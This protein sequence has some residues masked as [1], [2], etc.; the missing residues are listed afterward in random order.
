LRPGQVFRVTL[1]W[2]DAATNETG[3]RVYRDGVV[4]ATLPAKHPSYTDSPPMGGPYTYAVE[5]ISAGTPRRRVTVQS[6]AC[7]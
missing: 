6:Q 4:L 5:A 1:Q 3:Y 2:V 7:Q